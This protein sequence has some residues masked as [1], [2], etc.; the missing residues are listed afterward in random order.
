[1]TG[2]SMAKRIK[3]HLRSSMAGSLAFC[4]AFSGFPGQHSPAFLRISEAEAQSASIVR[5]TESGSGIRKRL[6]LGLNKALVID[7]PCRCRNPYVQ[8]HLSVRKNGGPDQY[9]HFRRWRARNRQS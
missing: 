2:S 1:M 9:L 6:K 8:A 4:L 7:L 3:Q 5:I